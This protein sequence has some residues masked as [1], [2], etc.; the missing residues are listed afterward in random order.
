MKKYLFTMEGR[1]V[2]ITYIERFV[3]FGGVGVSLL[4]LVGLLFRNY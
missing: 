2:V 1:S 4:V 3:I